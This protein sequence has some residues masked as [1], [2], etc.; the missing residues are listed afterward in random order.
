LCDH[1]A[2][3]YTKQM[4]LFDPKME[5]QSMQVCCHYFCGVWTR[6]TGRL[7]YASVVVGQDLVAGCCEGWDVGGPGLQVVG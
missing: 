6:W 2:H 5:E 1:A 4:K 7:A 3:A